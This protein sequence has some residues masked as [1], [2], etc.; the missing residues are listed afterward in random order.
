MPFHFVMIQFQVPQ[1][2]FLEKSALMSFETVVHFS[3]TA[4]E[5]GNQLSLPPLADPPKL[6][7]S[8]LPHFRC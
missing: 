5:S 1:V 4:A 8:A 6:V 2:A 7:H 3:V